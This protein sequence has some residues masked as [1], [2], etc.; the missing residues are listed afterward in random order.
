MAP[1]NVRVGSLGEN[2]IIV[3]FDPV[4]L[5]QQ[6]GQL[7]GYNVYYKNNEHHNDNEGTKITIGPSELQV[8]IHGLEFMQKY[9][10]SVSAFNNEEGPRS[11]RLEFVI[12][13]GHC[14]M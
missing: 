6:N 5:S 13:K 9:E 3:R 8:V 14:Y 12:G 7:Q 1:L 10:V 4:P 11:E 2:S